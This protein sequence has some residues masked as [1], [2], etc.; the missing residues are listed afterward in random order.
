M[1]DMTHDLFSFV[2]MSAIEWCA[3]LYLFSFYFNPFAFAV[4]SIVMMF[5]LL[6]D[7]QF[8][9]K[10]PKGSSELLTSEKLYEIL[11]T[12]DQWRNS[13]LLELLMSTYTA[14]DKEGLGHRMRQIL[15]E[16]T[17]KGMLERVGK[18]MYSVIR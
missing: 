16:Y 1:R 8:M 17:K 14:Y 11:K 3:L 9:K 4:Y 13:E 10:P 5:I 6:G 7:S 18:G 2:K 12:R 15:S